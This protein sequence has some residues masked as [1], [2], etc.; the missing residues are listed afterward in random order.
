MDS[1]DRIK[2]PIHC[3]FFSKLYNPGL[4]INCSSSLY[5]KYFNKTG[6]NAIPKI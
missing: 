2:V 5:F 4:M 6:C 1:T 3:R